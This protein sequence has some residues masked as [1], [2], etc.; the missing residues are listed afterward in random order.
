MKKYPQLY[1]H[2]ADIV[3][4]NIP[5]TKKEPYIVDMGVGPGIL[6]SK[7][8]ENIPD[9]KIIGIDPNKEMLKLAVENNKNNNFETRIGSS[10]KIPIT[11]GKSN[12]VVSRFSLTYWD[13]PKIS[14]AEINR[15]LKP[16][17]KVVLEFLN[18]DFPRWKLFLIKIHMYVKFAGSDI[19]RYHIDGY[20]TAYSIES[21]KKLFSDAGF[22]IKSIEGSKKDWKFI[23]VAFKK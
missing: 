10:E 3:K 19:V 7:I 23:I 17:G 9:A 20:K 13:R 5:K 15:V 6:T 11:N 1:E 2:L 14:F 16:K 22:K 4:R 12:L 21:V 18:K 8:F